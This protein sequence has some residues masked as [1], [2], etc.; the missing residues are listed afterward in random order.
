MSD[1]L[2]SLTEGEMDTWTQAT[3]QPFGV[4]IALLFIIFLLC[5]VF[6]QY[7]LFLLFYFPQLC[8]YVLQ[9]A[10]RGAEYIDLRSR[11]GTCSACDSVRLPS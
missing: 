11:N 10:K 8:L 2:M 1:R 9:I 3:G 7:L 4:F 5:F 6:V